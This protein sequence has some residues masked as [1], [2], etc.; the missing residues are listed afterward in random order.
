[1]PRPVDSSDLERLGG[2]LRQE[3]H[4]MGEQVRAELR[5]EIQASAAET[6][7]QMEQFES[8]LLARVDASAA[9]TRRYMG[10]VAEDLRSDIKAVAGG[11]GALDEKVE[12]FRGEVREDFGRVDRRLLHLEVRV[13]GRSGPA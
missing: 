3:M 7:L 5:Q 6:R 9:E 11:L 1:M 10:V 13:I 4:A 8:R 2:D 12:R